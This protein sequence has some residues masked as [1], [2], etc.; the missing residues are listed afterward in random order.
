MFLLK[1]DEQNVDPLHWRHSGRGGRTL[2]LDG[3]KTAL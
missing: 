2:G 1:R 3:V